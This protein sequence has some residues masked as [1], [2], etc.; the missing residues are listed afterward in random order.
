LTAETDHVDHKTSL[1]SSVDSKQSV[2]YSDVK[3]PDL[4]S[5]IQIVTQD[6]EKHGGKLPNDDVTH[7]RQ[8][9]NDSVEIDQETKLPKIKLTHRQSQQHAVQEQN[10]K[11][12][13]KSKPSLSRK[14]TVSCS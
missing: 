8:D 3:L 9:S 2:E 14:Q 11:K 4:Q 13:A 1:L 12:T 5:A 6:I 10:R 7:I